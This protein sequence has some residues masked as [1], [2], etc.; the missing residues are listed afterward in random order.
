MLYV[1]SVYIIIYALFL[2]CIKFLLCCRLFVKMLYELTTVLV[3]FCI[4]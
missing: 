3:T 4:S 2:G 1:L